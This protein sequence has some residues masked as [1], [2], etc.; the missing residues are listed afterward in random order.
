MIHTADAQ[1]CL[2]RPLVRLDHE[3]E[4]V[5]YGVAAMMDRIMWVD[6]GQLE[7][8][9]SAVSVALLGPRAHD[10]I[11][12]HPFFWR[13]SVVLSLSCSSSQRKNRTR[14][15]AFVLHN[16]WN[17]GLEMPGSLQIRYIELVENS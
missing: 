2:S 12:G 8:R 15:G 6:V 7:N 17:C 16:R 11:F 4:T 14:G 3:S 13:F 10:A 9:W 5:C 1:R